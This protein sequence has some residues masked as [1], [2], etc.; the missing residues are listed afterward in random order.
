MSE[1]VVRP[2]GSGVVVIDDEGNREW[3]PT[4]D[5][6]LRDNPRALVAS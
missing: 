2:S 6:A 5:L 4:L 1:S 3:Y